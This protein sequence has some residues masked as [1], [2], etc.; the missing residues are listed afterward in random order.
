M[1]KEQNNT[2]RH[3][4][5]NDNKDTSIKAYFQGDVFSYF[6]FKKIE[7]VVSALYLITN[8]IKDQEPIKWSIREVGIDLLSFNMNLKNVPFADRPM[9]LT[10]TIPCL[11]DLVSL[12]EVASFS[13]VLSN[14]NYSIVRNEVITLIKKIDDKERE[15]FEG[16][17]FVLSK[18]F[19]EMD[20]SLEADIKMRNLENQNLFNKKPD[21][22]NYTSGNN[23]QNSNKNTQSSNSTNKQVVPKNIAINIDK[24]TRRNKILEMLSSGNSLTLRDFA[25]VIKDCSEK[26]IQRELISMSKEGTLDK[27]GERRWSRYSIRRP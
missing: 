24:A 10:K 4:S 21:S 20:P 17:H 19:F 5:D 12:L 7:K 6:V 22:I 15:D 3:N 23:T 8:L 13:G 9:T 18:H 26:T 25:N 11:L 2:K 16:R 27:Q 1:D 14:M